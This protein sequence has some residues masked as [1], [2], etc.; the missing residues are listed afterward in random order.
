MPERQLVG[1]PSPGRP[2]HGAGEAHGPAVPARGHPDARRGRSRAA[3]GTSRS[4]R[5][6]G[7]RAPPNR[8]GPLG[9]ST[10]PRACQAS[11]STDTPGWRSSTANSRRAVRHVGGDQ[12]VG[13][14]GGERAPRLVPLELPPPVSSLDGR[15]GTCP[16]PPRRRRPTWRWRAPRR[17]S[18]A[19]ARIATASRWASSTRA[20]VRLTA[21]TD[22]SSSQRC[23]VSPEPGSGTVSV[24]PAATASASST[25]ASRRRCATS[26]TQG[27]ARPG[28]TRTASGPSLVL[29]A[30][31]SRCCGI[32]TRGSLPLRPDT[33]ARSGPGVHPRHGMVRRP[34]LGWTLKGCA[35]GVQIG[36]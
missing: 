12:R 6:G 27:A 19:S 14:P 35:A 20:A 5:P 32:D 10:S 7:P 21:A 9:T 31:S 28:P 13:E 18:P 8:T 15:R 33:W 3:A 34:P 29:P 2:R 4:R 24:S 1:A 26:R 23:R 11:G 17:A 30:G 25:S 36:R 22:A 16:E